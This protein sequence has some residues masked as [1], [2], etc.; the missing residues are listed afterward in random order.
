MVT[1]T[2]VHDGL[3]ANTALGTEFVACGSN[4][5]FRT[6]SYSIVSTNQILL[7]TNSITNVKTIRYITN[8][9]TNP[10]IFGG[11]VPLFGFSYSFY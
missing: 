3:T 10:I 6:V 5:A 9:V 7:Y 2:D 4:G 8:S 1:F 11:G